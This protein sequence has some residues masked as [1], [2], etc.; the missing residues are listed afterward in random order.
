[1]YPITIM[2]RRSIHQ[3]TV[4]LGIEAASHEVERSTLHGYSVKPVPV[5][6]F[7]LLQG[8]AHKNKLMPK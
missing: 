6:S 4:A 5:V 3:T 1:M 7:A 2:S 8:N